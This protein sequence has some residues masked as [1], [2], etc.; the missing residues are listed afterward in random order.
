MRIISS[1]VL[2][3]FALA[4][5]LAAP[6]AAQEDEAAG[7]YRVNQLI[8]YGD[9][10]CPVSTAAEITVCARKDEGERYRIP[11]DLRLSEDPANSAW[12]ERVLAYE[13]VGNTGINSCSPVGGGGELGCTQQL[14]DKAA[15]ERKESSS[16]RFSELIAKAREE[17]MSGVDAEAAAA[18]A[19]VEE[20]EAAYFE[21][22]AAEDA[23]GPVELPADKDD[24]T[25]AYEP[26]E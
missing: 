17:R 21:R 4:L 5:G 14:I 6:V 9:D 12:T 26:A 11:E 1:A 2:A 22:K 7:D 23:A 3:T 13:T 24:G 8:I 18:Q 15:A 10:E 16:I 20:E 25:A 19:R